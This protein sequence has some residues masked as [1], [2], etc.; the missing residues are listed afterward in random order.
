LFFNSGDSAFQLSIWLAN[1]PLTSTTGRGWAA[2]GRQAG[3]LAPGGEPPG[4]RADAATAA[5]KS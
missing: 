3:S 2:D 1:V 4:C 5:G